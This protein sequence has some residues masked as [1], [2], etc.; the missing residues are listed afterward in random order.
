MYLFCD[1]APARAQPR[2]YPAPTANFG[3][4]LA[5]ELERKKIEFEL[6]DPGASGVKHADVR[7]YLIDKLKATISIRPGEAVP[8]V[9][10]KS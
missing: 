8:P 1:T 7:A 3:V 9:T 6:N 10:S 4:G 2:D 5:K